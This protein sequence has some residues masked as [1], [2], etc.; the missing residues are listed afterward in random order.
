MAYGRRPLTERL[1]R[2]AR[3]RNAGK[4]GKP[5]TPAYPPHA[6]VGS[7]LSNQEPPLPVL[8]RIVKVPVFAS[9]GQRVSEHEVAIVVERISE[10]HR[11]S[12]DR[13]ASQSL[14][15]TF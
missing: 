8:R 9:D 4:I 10:P 3:F 14:E 15:Q 13:G 2:V 7:L 11:R 6:V 12:F 5:P 1:A